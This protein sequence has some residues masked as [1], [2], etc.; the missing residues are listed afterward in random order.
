MFILY[1]VG[2]VLS[3]LVGGVIGLTLATARYDRT[4]MRQRQYEAEIAAY[5]EIYAAMA[6]Y[7]RVRPDGSSDENASAA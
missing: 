7:R 4:V 3:L 6:L 1:N 2:L 5:Q